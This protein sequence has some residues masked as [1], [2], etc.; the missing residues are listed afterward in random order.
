MTLNPQQMASDMASAIGQGAPT[1]QMIGEATAIISEIMTSGTV[2]NMVGTVMGTAPPSGGP[3]TLGS[4]SQG[5]ILGVA[6]ASLAA[7]FQSNMGF[8]SI[9]PQLLQLATGIATH[10]L[11]GLVSFSPG[12]IMGVCSNTA[13]SPGAFTGL[14]CTNGLISGLDGSVMAN[15]IAPAFGG[16]PS[17]QLLDKCKAI[18]T[19]IMSMGIV[20]YPPGA[21]MGVCSTGG[22]PIA[23]GSGVGGKIT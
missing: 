9:T 6:G 12:M 23:A 3:L 8:P 20:T 21:V 13:T 7:S 10:I 15:I 22:G 11:T 14:A 4:A 19:D 5:T 1:M 18:C 16:P 2:L 17:K